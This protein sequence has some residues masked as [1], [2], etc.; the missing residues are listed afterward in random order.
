LHEQRPAAIAGLAVATVRLELPLH[1]AAGVR[2]VAEV[3][4]LPADAEPKR[5]ANALA[6]RRDLV[7]RE[8]ARRAQRIDARVPQRL[9][10]VDVPEAGD[11][12]LVEDRRLDRRAPSR[13]AAGEEGRREPPAERLRPV[14]DREVPFRGLF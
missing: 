6:Q 11:R 14:L 13:E 7:R 10:R 8:V 3:G 9:V 5:L 12:A 1:P 4:A 2:A